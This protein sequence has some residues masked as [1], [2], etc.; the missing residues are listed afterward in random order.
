MAS[1]PH[2]GPSR[3][4]VRGDRPSTSLGPGTSWT[5]PLQRCRLGPGL[6]VPAPPRSSIP[7]PCHMGPPFGAPG[8]LPGQGPCLLPHIQLA[9][10]VRGG[11]N[12]SPSTPPSPRSYR[13]HGLMGPPAL[14]L[15]SGTQQAFPKGCSELTWCI[16]A[17]WP[18]DPG[19]LLAP[20][21]LAQ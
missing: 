2:L 12:S 15:Q 18:R 10:L 9:V 21:L 19:L 14:S 7:P 8:R 5:E 16:V 17:D 11:C 6:Q 4:A 20:E 13:F 1:E 3:P